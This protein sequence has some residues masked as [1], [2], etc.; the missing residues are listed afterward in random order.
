MFGGLGI[1][2]ALGLGELAVIVLAVPMAWQLV[3]SGASV[4]FPRGFLIWAVFVVWVLASLSMLGA[5]PPGTLPGSA[6]ERLIPAAYRLGS[7]AA[8]AVVLVYAGNL[9]LIRYPQRK[10]ARVLGSGFL[11]VALGG[12]LGMFAPLFEFTSPLE[13]LLP[14]GLRSDKFVLSFVHPIAAQVQDFLGY[15]AP[16]PAAPFGYTNAWGHA[17]ALLLPWFVVGFVVYARGWRRLAGVAFIAAAMVP[18]IASMNRGMWVAIALLV[19]YIV[20][21]QF[22]QGR[23]MV[24]VGAVMVTL[25][26]GAVIALSPLGALIEQRLEN[27]RSDNIR[28]FSTEKALE[29]GAQSPVLGFGST[30]TTYGSAESIAVGKTPECPNC[31]NIPI[32][33]NG[34]LWSE[35]VGR[36]Y[37]GAVLYVGTFAMLVWRFRRDTTPIGLAAHAGLVLM[38]WCMFVYPSLV[39]PLAVAFT[40]WA[41]LWRNQQAGVAP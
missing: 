27:G 3:R 19:A 1:W 30:R 5:D 36:G 10:L 40:S 15:E 26:A 2:W 31:G 17:F 23:L 25:L 29:L 33:I 22:L 32:G 14:G 16:R 24:T 13:I 39:V 21:R 38:L 18:A 6:S 37:V 35:I 28:E 7:F 9:D 4:R 34:Q 12:Y 20:I 8:A 41:A 11:W